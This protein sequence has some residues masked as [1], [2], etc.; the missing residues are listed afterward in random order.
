MNSSA[1]ENALKEG[2]NK[3]YTIKILPGL[4][5]LFQTTETDSEYEYVQI[6]ETFSPDVLSLISS[7]D[8]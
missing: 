4:N 3:N 6:D 1:V 2:E 5:H 7:L 8:S